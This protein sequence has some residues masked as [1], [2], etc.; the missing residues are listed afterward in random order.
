MGG[1]AQP[2]S[3]RQR[4]FLNLM[5]GVNYEVRVRAVSPIGAGEYRTATTTC[6][7][8]CVCVCVCMCVYVCVCVCVC[9]CVRA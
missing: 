8:N 1:L 6:M 4:V 5:N 2:A 7:P 3:S 9:V